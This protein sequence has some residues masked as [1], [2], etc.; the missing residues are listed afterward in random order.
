MIGPKPETLARENIKSEAMSAIG[1]KRN[2]PDFSRRSQIS[3]NAKIPSNNHFDRSTVVGK[4]TGEYD[5]VSL[6]GTGS[7]RGTTLA[8]ALFVSRVLLLN[9]NSNSIRNSNSSAYS[10]QIIESKSASTKSCST[11]S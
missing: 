11:L 4:H 9:D 3:A 8:G 6:K 2:F 10:I 1:G 5:Q 7:F